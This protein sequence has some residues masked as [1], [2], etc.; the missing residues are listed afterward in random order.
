MLDATNGGAEVVAELAYDDTTADNLYPFILEKFQSENGVDVVVVSCASFKGSFQHHLQISSSLSKCIAKPAKALA[1]QARQ[2]A[3]LQ[4][5]IAALHEVVVGY[6]P[7]V[8]AMLICLPTNGVEGAFASVFPLLKHGLQLA[9]GKQH[10]QKRK[11]SHGH[12][13]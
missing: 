1:L 5:P 2:G 13:H 11:H 9:R 4:N 8:S 7:Q 12:H 10:G 6:V 3:A